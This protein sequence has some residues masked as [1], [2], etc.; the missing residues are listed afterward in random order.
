MNYIEEDP[1]PRILFAP[2]GD[3]VI[4]HRAPTGIT[5]TKRSAGEWSSERVV[6]V[7]SAPRPNLRFLFDGKGEPHILYTVETNMTIAQELRH[8]YRGS[9]PSP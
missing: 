3:P 8:A 4:V 5:M 2:N 6:S 7:V 9:C 1:V